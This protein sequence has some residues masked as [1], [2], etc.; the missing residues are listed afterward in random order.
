MAI[1]LSKL[2]DISVLFDSIRSVIFLND[3]YDLK[4]N[5]TEL[6]ILSSP[7]FTQV[8]QLSDAP[9]C[10]ACV[11]I[12]AVPAA[13]PVL[14]AARLVAGGAAGADVGGGLEHRAAQLRRKGHGEGA[15]GVAQ[16]TMWRRRTVQVFQNQAVGGELEDVM[17]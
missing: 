16:H 5:N 12:P 2:P 15:V 7:Q 3:I 13:R 6:C 14:M 4:Q 8:F 11:S 17:L 9:M 1:W 10:A